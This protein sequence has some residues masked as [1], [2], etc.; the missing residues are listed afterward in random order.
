MREFVSNCITHEREFQGGKKCQAN[1]EHSRGSSHIQGF[2]SHYGMAVD[3]LL[4]VGPE[5]P[6][7][8]YSISSKTL[9]LQEGITAH[10][11]ISSDI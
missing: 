7:R 4:Q 1:T 10:V 6:R 3:A 11:S 5:E 8:E 9:T 2:G